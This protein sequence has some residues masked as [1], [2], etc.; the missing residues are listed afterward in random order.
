MDVSKISL[1][2]AEG[3]Y[4]W[5][6]SNLSQVTVTVSVWWTDTVHLLSFVKHLCHLFVV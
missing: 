3:D 6:P 2:D 4:S 1:P 5:L